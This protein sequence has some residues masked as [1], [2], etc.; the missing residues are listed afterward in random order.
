MQQPVLAR[1]VEDLA[2]AGE[3]A[4]LSVEEMIRIL[5]AGVTVESLVDLIERRGAHLTDGTPR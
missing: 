3:K 5:N 1:A 4:G 2:R